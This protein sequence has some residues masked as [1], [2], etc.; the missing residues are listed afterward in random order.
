MSLPVIR[1]LGKMKIDVVCA[2]PVET[3]HTL[4]LGFVSK[5]ASVCTHL[6]APSRERDFIAALRELSGKEKPVIIPVG[7]ESLTA[8]S[9]NRDEVN[10]FAYTALPHIDSLTTANNKDRLMLQAKAL[11]I[12][13]PKTT[14]LQPEESTSKLAERI[15]Y[16]AVIKYR[17][18]ELLGFDPQDRYQ[19]VKNKEEMTT[20]FSVMHQKQEYPLVQEYVPGR[21][22]GVS[23]VFDQNHK[24]M[25]VFCH[26]RLREYPVS[27]GP[28]CYCQSAWN[29][30]LVRYAV[31][32]LKS[33]H[34]TGVAMV[35]FKGNPER[36]YKLME[37]NPRFWGS[38]ALAPIA[39]CDITKYLFHAALGKR[40]EPNTS[41]APDYRL[42]KKMR[43]FLQD[44]SSL[45]GYMKQSKKPFRYFWL[46]L[47]SLLNPTVR[48]GVFSFGD[49]KPA[50]RY[51]KNAFHKREK[52]IR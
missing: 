26:S 12:P 34:W 19:I 21:G 30:E 24:P 45:F 28:S 27:G 32:L 47:G 31:A 48:G 14:T 44:A 37:I 18:G 29:D 43:F 5:Y 7:M 9:R 38:S 35:E 51:L 8:L 23:A 4:S 20:A 3:P 41:L 46:H 39:G 13:C 42:N 17:Q 36:G 49:P 40:A 10:S 33:L 25:T 16:P 1:S 50:F 22:F 52:F 15:S 11:G 2:D 6:P